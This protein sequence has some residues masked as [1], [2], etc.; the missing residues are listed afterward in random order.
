[1]AAGYCWVVWF[2][3]RKSS[4]RVVAIHQ[5]QRQAEL[6]LKMIRESAGMV[7]FDELWAYAEDSGERRSFAR[8]KQLDPNASGATLNNA[9]LYRVERKPLVCHVDEFLEEHSVL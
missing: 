2:T 8:L 1:M 4:P 3:P 7:Q 9:D 6:H 5:N